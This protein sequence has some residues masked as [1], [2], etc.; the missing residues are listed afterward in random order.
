MNPLPRLAKVWMR[1]RIPPGRTQELIQKVLSLMPVGISGYGREYRRAI[2][3]V[4]ASLAMRPFGRQ[5]HILLYRKDLRQPLSPV[6]ARIPIDITLA[7]EADIDQIRALRP[8]YSASKLQQ[9][10][11]AGAKCFL[12]RFEQRV[13]GFNW[14]TAV[15]IDEFDKFFLQSFAKVNPVEI[16]CF[17]AFIDEAYRGNSVHTELLYRMLQHAQDTSC[18]YAY[19]SVESKHI[20]SWKTHIRLGWELL[21]TSHI[22]HPRWKRLPVVYVMSPAGGPRRVDVRP[23]SS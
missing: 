6:T 14:M 15:E 20:N 7:T 13:I 16:Y 5:Q 17:D 21:G 19:T 1:E 4:V 3:M 11:R 2:V 12:A 22:F 8:S 10:F 23:R 9:R 18:V